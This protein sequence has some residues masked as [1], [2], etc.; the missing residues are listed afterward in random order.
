[1]IEPSRRHGAFDP[2]F[3]IHRSG[4]NRPAA[5]CT[6][7]S[8]DGAGALDWDVFSSRLSPGRRHDFTLLKA[9]EAH[10]NSFCESTDEQRADRE[11]V[12]VFLAAK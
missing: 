8:E 9:Y 1:M 12:R 3:T 5:S 10:R 6:P 4:G 11:P 7:G 2:R